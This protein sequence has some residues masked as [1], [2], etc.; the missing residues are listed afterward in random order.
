MKKT[1]LIVC[2]LLLSL[3]G[4]AVD[5]DP[6]NPDLLAQGLD[7]SWNGATYDAATKTIT[8]PAAWAGM[9][10]TF[11]DNGNLSAYSTL[12][13]EF[14]PVDYNIQIIVEYNDDPKT[15]QSEKSIPGS[16]GK[17]T[18]DILPTT[19]GQIVI[20]NSAAGTLTLKA[21][22]LGGDVVIE[23]KSVLD[24]E[25]DELGTVYP[26]IHGWGWPDAATKAEVAADPLGVSTKSLKFAAANYDA[27]AYFEVALPEGK[28]VANITAITFDSYFGAED[29][30]AAVELFIAPKTATVGGG[31][32]FSAYPV[33]LKS[34]DTV[35][36][37]QV[38]QANEWFNVSITREQI[39]DNTFN[40]N[41]TSDFTTVDPLT[42]FL[43]GIGVSVGGGTEY[44]L[45]NITFVLDGTGIVQVKPIAQ[46]CNT[47]GGILVNANNEKVSIYGIDGRLVKQTVANNN[48]ISLTQGAYIV[49]VGAAKPVKVLVK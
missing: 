9:G 44:Y 11:W 10:W 7:N 18:I 37:I 35:D 21:A 19:V 13:I 33:Y 47:A 27:V 46:V 23:P 43:F 26:T 48:T 14:E 5:A 16:V 30:F 32:A 49:K 31:T 29:K 41:A 12:T 45:D 42:Q 28:T 39:L 3:T 36:P 2:A 17:L 25:S 20:Q 8:Y 22:Y 6:S 34:P 38:G 4:F 24:F 40:S 15:P 1:L